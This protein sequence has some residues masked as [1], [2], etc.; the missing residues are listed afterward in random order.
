MSVMLNDN[1]ILNIVANSMSLPSTTICGPTLSVGDTA[2]T[3]K[4][5]CGE[6]MMINKGANSPNASN[7]PQPMVVLHYTNSTPPETLTFDHGKL[8]SRKQGE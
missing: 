1:K 8:S 5:T 2:D 4:A 6:P 7:K 3:L